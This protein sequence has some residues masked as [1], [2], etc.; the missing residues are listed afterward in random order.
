MRA[1]SRIVMTSLTLALAVPLLAGALGCD[2]CEE[3]CQ[4]DYDDC[5]TGPEALRDS[6][7][8][9]HDQCVGICVSQPRDPQY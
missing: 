6:C 8:A 5:M 9:E 4:E 3:L 1:L 7:N 2:D